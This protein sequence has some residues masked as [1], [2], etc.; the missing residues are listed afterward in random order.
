MWEDGLFCFFYFGSYTE[1]G[2]SPEKQKIL[3][4]QESGLEMIE[5]RNG[6]EFEIL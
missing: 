3:Q 4:I 6:K 5:P 2:E 1:A